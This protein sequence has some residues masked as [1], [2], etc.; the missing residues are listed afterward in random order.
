DV[1]MVHAI[2]QTCHIMLVEA[3]SSGFSDLGTAVSTAVKAGAT[4]G[5]NSYGG[6][7]GAGYSAYNTPYN[8]PGGP[9]VG[10]SRDCAYLNEACPQTHAA[11]FPASSPDVV[12]VGG[13]S[14]TKSGETWKS[15]AWNDAG[16]GCSH[17]FT[18][19]LWQSAAENFSATGCGSGR[20]VADVSAVADP[21]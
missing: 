8:Q 19:Q 4:V 9:V 2:C 5:S 3:N 6:A 1:Q 10:S 14:L 12:A 13:T 20:S 15:T 7:E 18:A 16:S 21:Y 17:V 11:N